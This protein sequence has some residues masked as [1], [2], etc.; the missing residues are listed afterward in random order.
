MIVISMGC[1]DKGVRRAKEGNEEWKRN[2]GP[3]TKEYFHWQENHR[4]L[5]YDPS[6]KASLGGVVVW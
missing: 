4:G 3:P 6:V 2:D 1:G 5:V